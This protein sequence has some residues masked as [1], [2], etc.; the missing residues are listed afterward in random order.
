M[1]Y[2]NLCP[3]EDVASQHWVCERA[4]ET[5]NQELSAQQKVRLRCLMNDV[6]ACYSGGWAAVKEEDIRLAME[7]FEYGCQL[8]SGANMCVDLFSVQTSPEFSVNQDVTQASK[9][10]ELACERG[11]KPGCVYLKRING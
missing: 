8:P 11:S 4:F 9:L 6:T 10:L 1:L 7:L 2:S 3:T 5:S